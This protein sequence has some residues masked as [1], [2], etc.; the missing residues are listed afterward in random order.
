VE[1]L[2]KYDL[3]KDYLD[4]LFQMPDKTVALLVRFLEQGK[5]R[6]SVRAKAREFKELTEEEVDIIENKYK[7]IFQES[8]I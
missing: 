6:L 7:D 8:K 5:G 3:M 2:E 4:N 1:Y